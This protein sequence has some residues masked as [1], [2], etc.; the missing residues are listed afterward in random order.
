MSEGIRNYKYDNLKSLLIFLVVLG[1]LLK[2]FVDINTGAKLLY[3]VIFSFHMPAFIYITGRF[4]KPNAK[5]AGFFF[6][7]YVIFN[8]IYLIFLPPISDKTADWTFIRP[9]WILWYLMSIIF[10]YLLLYV[11]PENLSVKTKRWIVFAS[12]ILAIL[13]GFISCIGTD[14]SLSRTIV[15]LPFFL[16]GKWRMLENKSEMSKKKMTWF[17]ILATTLSIVYCFTACGRYST[18]FHYSAYKVWQVDWFLR[19]FAIFIAAIWVR[20]LLSAIPNKKNTIVSDMGK[21]TLFIYLTHGLIVKLLL[22]LFGNFFSH[23]PLV[24]SILLAFVLTFLLYL[25]G[26]GWRVLI[27]SIK[28]RFYGQAS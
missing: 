25:G 4:A 14:L 23:S 6:G 11:L 22:F 28:K 1:H 15:F 17:G 16:M 9:M 5:R 19:T 12:I 10:Y 8:L 24:I 26:K 18:L 21:Y 20:F 7:L 2:P 3:M 27:T 13:I